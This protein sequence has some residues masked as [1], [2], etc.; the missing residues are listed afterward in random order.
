MWH[1]AVIRSRYL[2]LMDHVAY[3]RIRSRYITLMDQGAYWSD[4]IKIPHTDGP[5][6][7]LQ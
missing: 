6:G 4:Q 5:C 3:W 1:T 7:I 2:T